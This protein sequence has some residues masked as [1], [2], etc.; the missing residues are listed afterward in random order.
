MNKPHQ[1][2]VRKHKDWFQL[3]IEPNGIGGTLLNCKSRFQKIK[4]LKLHVLSSW[5]PR[6][7]NSEYSLYTRKTMEKKCEL[8]TLQSF[9]L[10]GLSS[11][12][13]KICIRVCITKLSQVL[14]LRKV[15]LDRILP[16]ACPVASIHF[17]KGIDLSKLKF[18]PQDDFFWLVT[19]LQVTL[20]DSKTADQT[21]TPP[22]W[23]GKQREATPDA[24]LLQSS[25]RST[26]HQHLHHTVA[27]VCPLCYSYQHP[28]PSA[29]TYRK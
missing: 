26:A 12:E 22:H 14:H 29:L 6:R 13:D 16:F 9:P 25:V 24:L 11:V 4:R 19:S 5:K 18:G 28:L 15:G 7:T 27:V 3:V 8:Q 23:E 21:K 20:A 2:G 10:L 17:S 1:S